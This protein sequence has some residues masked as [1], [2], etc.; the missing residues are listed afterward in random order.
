MVVDGEAIHL[1]QGHPGLES[2]AER[3]RIRRRI[4]LTDGGVYDNLGLEPV[5][6]SHRSVLVSDGGAVFRAR[7][8]RTQYGRILRILGIAASGGQSVRNRWL[9]ASFARKVITGSSWGLDTVLDGS[10]PREVVELVNAVRTDLDAFSQAE[11]HV[12]ERHGYLV[13]DHHVRAHAPDLIALDAPLV[14]PHEDV[15]DPAVAARALAESSVRRL[16]GRT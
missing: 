2:E 10:Y 9:H 12:L 7:T 1:T 8:E 11:Q 3:A 4:R 5:W 15:V 14:P 16:L 13:A 6:K